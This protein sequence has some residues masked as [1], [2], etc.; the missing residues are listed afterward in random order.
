MI[1]Q[2]RTL[3]I[4]CGNLSQGGAERIISVLSD[5]M[6]CYFTTIEIVTWVEGPVFYHFNSQIRIVSI[7]VESCTMNLL[8]RMCWFRKYVSKK[9]PYAVLSFLAPFNILT[10]SSLL[11]GNCRVLVAERSDPVYDCPNEFWRR[12]RNCSYAL[13]S[14]VCVQTIKAKEYFPSLIRKKTDVIYNPAFV[15]KEMIGKALSTP[16][17]KLVVSVGRLNKAKNHGLLLDAFNIVYKNNP[18]YKLVIYGEGEQRTFLENKIKVLG[19]NGVVELPGSRNDV[20][21]LLLDAEVFVMSSDYEG[22]PNALIEA[23]CLG[24]P[25]ISTR[26][27]GTAELVDDSRNG[28]LVDINDCKALSEAMLYMLNNKGKAY[29]MAKDA[30]NIVY[31]LNMDDIVQ[32]WIRFIE[33]G[34]GNME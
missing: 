15:K 19:L 17:Q 25:C 11:W 22:M 28:L 30:I 4:T 13:A 1:R 29:E 8:L 18:D 27:S 14:G 26:V 9:K 5:K 2:E 21:K 6:L 12:V 10:L 3:I 23:M 31:K 16:K 34:V 32:Q 24:L 33:K 7:P 20:H